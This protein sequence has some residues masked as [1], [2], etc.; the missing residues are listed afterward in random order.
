MVI[1]IIFIDIATAEDALSAISSCAVHRSFLK[2]SR[3]HQGRAALKPGIEKLKILFYW[4][5]Y[6]L[7]RPFYLVSVIFNTLLACL[8]IIAIAP[9]D[10]NGNAAHYVGKIWSLF[11]LFLSGTRVAVRGKEKIDKKRNYIV[12]SNHQSLFDVLALIGKMP[13]QIRW[14]IKSEIKKI[15]VFGYTLKRM[16]H[17]YVDRKNREAAAVSLENAAE[18]IREG[19]SVTIFP[20][21][22][23]SEDGKLLKFRLG[24]GKIAIKSGVPILPVTINGSRFALPKNTLALMPGKIE[25]VVG[26][27]IDPGRYDENS[28]DDLM[29]KVKSIISENLDLEFGKL[30]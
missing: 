25:I 19:T 27:I 18:K 13:L 23:R 9:L 14:I 11:N 29:E 7:I 22:T 8:V 4:V 1:L 24:G 20:E 28:K 12:M 16:G 26:D 17:I 3:P 6:P 5:L 15:P 30:T 21:G 10:R 2:P